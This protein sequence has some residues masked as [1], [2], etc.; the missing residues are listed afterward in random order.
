MANSISGVS[1]QFSSVLKKLTIKQKVGIGLSVIV[2][3]IALVL[4]VRWAN[5]PTYGVLFS[6]LE[7]KDASKIMDKLKQ[8][9]VPY[10][11]GEG[12]KAILVPKDKVYE[13]RL[14]MA[15]AGLPQSS[16]VGYEI[17]DKPTFGMTDFTE[18]VDY[19]RALEGELERTILQLDEVQGAS[20]HIVI[21]EKALF[22]SQQQKTTAS[23][24]LK[25]RDGAHLTA[26]EISG[27]QH[28]VAASVEGLDANNVT[29]VDARGNML[30]RKSDGI[31]ALTSAQYD[32]QDKVDN[33]LASKAQ[34]MLDAVLGPGNAIVRVTADLD[35]NQMDKTTE[36][37]DPNSVVLSQQTMQNHASVPGDTSS[38]GSSQTNSVTNYDVGKTVERMVGST[39]GIKRLSVAVL[40]NGKYTA[41]DKGKE[42]TVE[43]TPRNQQEL[44]QLTNIVKSAIGFDATR[45]DDISL[46]NVPFENSDQEFLLKQ[47][48][49]FR[50]QDY[51]DKLIILAAMIGAIIVFLSIFKRLK[52]KE[53]TPAA[54]VAI[55]TQTKTSGASGAVAAEHPGE[56]LEGIQAIEYNEEILRAGRIKED[57]SSYI[58]TKPLDAAKLLKVWLTE[59]S[60]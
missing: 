43:Y 16:T 19:K 56:R 20:V 47:K 60:D 49:G 32:T 28:L 33:Y 17:F 58:Q 55:L 26:G 35:F 54:P 8:Q 3:I 30:S 24:F 7:A 2:S 1:S 48:P 18:K 59:G 41:I 57:V 12:G 15:G 27:V 4:L 37:Y 14:Q 38:T 10:E 45:G 31:D 51:S 44:T 5:Q 46:V 13:L 52:K 50:I 9:A 53:S 42:R 6:N 11:I 23:V 36:Q 29:I 34:T 22:E 21:P 39:G 40:V 25:L